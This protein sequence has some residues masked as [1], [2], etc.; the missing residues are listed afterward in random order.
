MLNKIFFGA[1]ILVLIIY[2]FIK[3]AMSVALVIAVK[4]VC[5]FLFGVKDL[6]LICLS[7]Q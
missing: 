5:N 6:F 1:Y 4:M 3:W 7:G 2:G